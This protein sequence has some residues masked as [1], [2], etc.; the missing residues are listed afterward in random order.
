MEKLPSELLTHIFTYLTSDP[1]LPLIPL[2]CSRWKAAHRNIKVLDLD[3]LLS[4]SKKYNLQKVVSYFP[5][6]SALTLRSK[7][8]NFESLEEFTGSPTIKVLEFDSNY[9]LPSLRH[10]PKLQTLI[11]L[12]S[13]DNQS[14]ASVPTRNLITILNFLP[15]L[16]VLQIHN[17]CIW[18]R[19]VQ[20]RSYRSLL[21]L[22]LL[23]LDRDFI[24]EFF[25]WL[26]AGPRFSNLEELYMDLEYASIPENAIKA[27][28]QGCPSL[29]SFKLRF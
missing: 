25:E 15:L 4:K 7:N 9:L 3:H 5:C 21:K 22:R 8:L 12:P 29:S 18:Q 19:N 17:P 1:V 24:P 26:S 6:A 20:F 14:S 28:S 13:A 27:I 23:N 16:Q 11:I 10:C 2:V